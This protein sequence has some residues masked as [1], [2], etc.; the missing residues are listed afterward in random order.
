M[1]PLPAPAPGRR[2]P[3]AVTPWRAPGHRVLRR[4]GRTA[5]IHAPQAKRALTPSRVEFAGVFRR[6]WP[7]A[8]L[9]IGRVA[10][11]HQAPPHE[12]TGPA[13]ST[14]QPDVLRSTLR[15]L[16]RGRA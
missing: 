4:P 5:E 14:P 1:N 8:H 11:R 16:E 10:T 9:R 2:R 3:T 6:V 12:A 13:G 7:P 15:W